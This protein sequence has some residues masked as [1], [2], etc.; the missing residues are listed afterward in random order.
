MSPVTCMS[1]YKQRQRANDFDGQVYALTLFEILSNIN[2]QL[3]PVNPTQ[4]CKRESMDKKILVVEDDP[5]VRE[6]I[7]HLLR[8]QG[9]SIQ[10]STDLYDALNALVFTRFD[11]VLL[12]LNL[13][14]QNGFVVMDYL[15][16]NNLATRVIIITG[17]SS[18]ATAITALKK[19][20]AD[21]LKKPFEPEELLVSV[22]KA[23]GQGHFPHQ[24]ENTL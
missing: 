22:N 7:C 9:Y 23:L 3:N 8:S 12:D 19:G 14:E 18:E 15:S 2:R 16:I 20:A 13:E 17:Q 21:Y 4:G 6:S 1:G 5:R 10:A 24:K 11:L